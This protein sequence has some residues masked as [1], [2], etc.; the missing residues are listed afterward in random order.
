V[1]PVPDGARIAIL[2]AQGLLQGLSASTSH[3]FMIQ[4][5]GRG[6]TSEGRARALKQTFTL[7][8]IMAVAGSLAAQYIL[9]PGLPGLPYPYDFALLYGIGAPCMAAVAVFAS[10]FRAEPMPDEPRRPFVRAQVESI[11]AYFADPALARVWMA[12]LLFY[13]TLGMTSNLALYTREAVGRDPAELSGLVMAIRFGCKAVFGLGIGWLAVRHGLRAAVLGCIALTIASGAWAWV[14]PGYSYVFAFGLL[15]GGELGGIYIPNLVA[16]LSALAVG[17][18]NLAIITLATPASSYA[19][20]AHGWLTDL[21][22]FP[23]S[24]AFAIATALGALVLVR[25]VRRRDR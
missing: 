8:P 11:R 7:T 6:T 25:S 21:F 17:P 10:R 19:P 9:S 22:G 16:A 24:F 20:V 5:L 4:C 2:T 12:Y 1:L 23:A 13:T 14:A 18:R 3:V 15:G